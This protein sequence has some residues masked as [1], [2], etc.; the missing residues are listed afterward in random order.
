[1]SNT[2]LITGITGQDGS[3]LAELLLDKGYDVYGLVRHTSTPNTQN[4]HHILN[5]ITLITGD[6]TD[7][8]SLIRALYIARPNEVYNLG[9]ISHVGASFHEPV[10][11]ME[12]TGLGCTRMLE[13]IRLTGNPSIRF[14]QASSS[15]IIGQP[16]QNVF[17]PRSPYA[18]AKLYA[19]WTVNNYRDGYGLYAVSGVLYNHESPRRGENFVTRKITKAVSRI[20]YGLQD[21]LILGNTYA[22]R[23][24]GYAGDY[25]RAM[26]LMLQQPQPKD[27][28]ISTGVTHT[29]EYFL[30]KAF[31]AAGI[32]DYEQYVEIHGD[33]FRPN[34]VDCLIGDSS[35]AEKDLGWR[36]TV[37][38]D[39][40]VSM[41]VES[42][43]KDAK[44]VREKIVC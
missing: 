26:W 23:D 8:S 34:D 44:S 31:E 35:E 25:V 17:K 18:S 20:K 43:L 15:E 37:S 22:S 24:W 42:D 4:I 38:F 16:N 27:Y 28:I 29:V 11:T 10:A 14:Y 9:A 39:E 21:K 3:Y 40:L 6:L 41:M 5:K 30:K 33:Q 36:P 1:M 12:V 32:H 19:H 2:A 7:M 13:A